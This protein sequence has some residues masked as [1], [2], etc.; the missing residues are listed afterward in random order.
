MTPIPINLAVEDSLSEAVLRKIIQYS[1]RPYSI[2]VCYSHEG[3]GYLKKTI[4]GFNNAAKGTPFLVLTDLDTYK[5]PQALIKKWLPNP[6]NPNLLFRVAVRE[7]ESWILA[8]QK[9]I[10]KYLGIQ[11][12]LV[13]QN[14]DTL[15]DPKKILISLADKSR[16]KELREAIVP[17]LGGQAEQGPDYNGALIAFVNERWNMNTAKSASRSLKKAVDAVTAFNPLF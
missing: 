14:P 4:K 17:R 10:A 9:G 5:C 12:I 8:D 15:T 7:V 1:G 3:Y 6:K 13:P 2:G 11:T 16:K